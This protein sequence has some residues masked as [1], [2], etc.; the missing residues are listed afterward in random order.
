MKTNTAPLRVCLFFT[1][2]ISLKRWDELG[3]LNREVLLYKDLVSSGIEVAFFTYGDEADFTYA[4]RIPGIKIIPA[5]AGNIKT[6]NRKAA[7]FK[8]IWIPF[9]FK[10]IFVQYDILK[11]NQIWGGWVPLIAKWLTGKRLLVR[12]GFEHYYTL[13]RENHPKAERFIFCL[14]SRLLYSSSNHIIVTT[15]R[16]AEFIR[17]TFFISSDKISVLPNLIDTKLFT[18]NNSDALFDRRV[19]FIGRLSRQKNLFALIEACK[20]LC[21]GLDLI[22]EGALMAELKEAVERINADVRFLGKYDNTQLPSIIAKYPIFVLPSFYEGCPKAL[23][24]AMSCGRAVVG[25]DVDGIREIIKDGENGLLCNFSSDGIAA[26]ISRL[27]GNPQLC[28]KLGENARRYIIENYSTDKV[29]N[30]ELEIYKRIL[31]G[32]HG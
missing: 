10:N 14:F 26:A 8:S 5:Y 21:V 3:I 27:I 11:T 15:K 18:V 2:G 7:F 1:Y 23:L 6:K 28:R 17:K 20:K 16:I 13:I 12:C 19:I 25:T 24:E 32:R 22:G 9:K 30:K 31:K 4:E 29:V